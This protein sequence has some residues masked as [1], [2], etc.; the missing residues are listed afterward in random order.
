[1]TLLSLNRA[2]APAPASQSLSS[3]IVPSVT[4]AATAFAERLIKKDEKVIQI[5]A[6][7]TGLLDFRSI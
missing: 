5:E 7:I 1:V 2:P 4:A 6:S 3:T